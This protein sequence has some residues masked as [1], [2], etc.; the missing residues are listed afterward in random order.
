MMFN[1]VSTWI[2]IALCIGVA[3]LMV[4]NYISMKRIEKRNK[5]NRLIM[6][7]SLGRYSSLSELGE[8]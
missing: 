1:Y 2:F 6:A 7:S 4:Y 8:E 5:I 3:G